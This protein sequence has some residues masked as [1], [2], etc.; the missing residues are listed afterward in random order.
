MSKILLIKPRFLVDF[1]N[2]HITQP[3]GLM[4][5]GAMLKRAGHEPKIHDCALDYKDLQI[6]RRTIKDWKPD[7]IGISIIITEV[8]QTKII[9]SIIREILPNVPV[10]F[11]G[12]WPSANPEESIKTL[13]SDFVVIGE[14]EL[15]F[16]LLIEA[17]NNGRPTES[18]SGTASMV[19]DHIKINPG[20][21]LTEDELNALPF[22]A[23]E[24]LDHKLYAKMHSFAL[25]GCRP[26]M[27]IVT[28][29]GCPYRC[30]YCHQTMGKV[31]RKRTA[32][33]V[34]AE[35]EE[36][37]FKYG[38]KE[39]EIAD[40]CFNLDRERM[41]AILTGIRD[42]LGDAKLYFPNGLRSDMIE[43]EDMTL[44]KQAGTVSAGFAIETSSPRLQ[45]MIHKNLNIEKAACAI[46]ASV[47]AGIYSIG[48]FIIGLPTETYEEAS[49]TVEFALRSPL[50]RAYF[51]YAMPFAG[52]EL[53]NMAADVLKNKS[54]DPGHMNYFDS[55]LNISAMS[56]SELQRVFR[57]AY[58]RFYMNP[59]RILRLII[60]YPRITS[61]PRYALTSL[62]KIIPRKHRAT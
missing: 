31:F 58:R 12:P 10:T 33:S 59:K 18:I 45:K 41:Y 50:H 5:I 20:N 9:M 51:L 62:V 3:M 1:E 28:S 39:F 7:F 56:D 48:F 13:G 15:V 37:R 60:R 52:T 49:A 36:I 54:L 17:V 8:E 23:W 16:P 6:L 57:R 24:L 11:G 38:F 2:Y 46:N 53:A 32:E 14:G 55:T 27:A 35:M 40:D 22:P 21:H 30:S 47:Q 34:L 29:R 26:Y 42:R 44:F 4:Y 19:N 43:P 25:V 61:L